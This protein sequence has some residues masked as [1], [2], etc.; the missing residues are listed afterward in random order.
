VTDVCGLAGVGRLFLERPGW[1][2]C[3]ERSMATPSQGSFMPMGD[4][5]HTLPAIGKQMGDTV[6]VHLKQ[7]VSA[8]QAP[9]EG[10]AA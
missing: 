9:H 4:G 6:R 3:G 8:D 2:R 5:T 1:W 10:T 7:R